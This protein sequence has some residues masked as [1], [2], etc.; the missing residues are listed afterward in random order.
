[1]AGGQGSRLAPLTNVV[2]KHLLPVYDKPMIYYPLATLMLSGVREIAI[3]VNP[4]NLESFE[5]LLGNGANFGIS[6]QYFIQDKP[7]GIP[8]GLIKTKKWIN[9]SNVLA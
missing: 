9:N 6:I 7:L 8:D 3:I 5:S 2:N 4:E 1:M